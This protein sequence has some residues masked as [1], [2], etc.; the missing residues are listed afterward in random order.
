MLDA[1]RD[2]NH[3]Y[4]Q[5]LEHHAAE[6]NEHQG[7]QTSAAAITAGLVV[8]ELLGSD[9]RQAPCGSLV[10]QACRMGVG[11]CLGRQLMDNCRS[12]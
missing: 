7:C 4:I 5:G 12:G 11:W 2:I 3:R 8:R 9:A 6:R 10:L 1:S